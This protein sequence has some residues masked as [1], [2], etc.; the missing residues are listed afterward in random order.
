[1]G[2][3]VRKIYIQECAWSK[4]RSLNSGYVAKS[5]NS[6]LLKQ[7]QGNSGYIISA[8]IAA[9]DSPTPILHTEKVPTQKCFYTGFDV[10][11]LKAQP[12]FWTSTN[13]YA[14]LLFWTKDVAE[15]RWLHRPL[16]CWFPMILRPKVVV[17]HDLLFL[18]MPSPSRYG[19]KHEWHPC[20]E[21][22]INMTFSTI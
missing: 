20:I 8:K 14:S 2:S 5:L 22:G 18:F 13:L 3:R 12:L 7:Q 4:I 21:I 17:F 19:H 11:L 6:C 16:Q 10:R 9:T 1:M 15:P